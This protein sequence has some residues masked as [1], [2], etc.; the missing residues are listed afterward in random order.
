VDDRQPLLSAAGPQWTP[1]G[2]SLVEMVITLTI[3][4]CLLMVMYG[5]MVTQALV[6]LDENTE[7]SNQAQ[8]RESAQQLI[9]ELECCM[10][11]RLDSMG[12]WFEYYLPNSVT[13]A[14]GNLVFGCMANGN[15]YPNGFYSVAFVRSNESQDLLYEAAMSNGPSY[16]VD[17]NNNG[18]T[19]DV[20]VGGFLVIST[21][22]SGGNPI[23]QPRTLYGKLFAE[24]LPPGAQ[25]TAVPV[26][27][28]PTSA[29]DIDSANA[30]VYASM[31]AAPPTAAA[32][33]GVSTM[34]YRGTTPIFLMRQING[35]NS[36]QAD[37]F[38]DTNS[39]GIL[40]QNE[41][42]NDVNH[43]GQYDEADCEPFSDDN[44]NNIRDA[45]EAYVDANHNS[46]Y[47]CRM[48]LQFTTYDTSRRASSAETSSTNRDPY[49]GLRLMRTKIRFKN[50]P[51]S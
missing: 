24:L 45:L 37:T 27:N 15:F 3:T 13:D 44:G 30:T 16:G 36:Q 17:L 48:T 11:R 7:V 8:I 29:E 28:T 6:T 12:M 38:N 14:N 10:P 22:D 41:T 51:S 1:R 34:A 21:Y 33:S 31:G 32:L 20:F 9:D 40:D 23:G 42:Y 2:F 47:D 39:D 5:F 49:F 43:N 50:L 19:T 26:T 18:S 46:V 25:T 4:C 35:V